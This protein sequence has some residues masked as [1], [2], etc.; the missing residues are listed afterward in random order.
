MIASSVT[1]PLSL[2]A[3]KETMISWPALYSPMMRSSAASKTFTPSLRVPTFP[4]AHHQEVVGIGWQPAEHFVFNRSVQIEEPLRQPLWEGVDKATQ[5]A[6]LYVLEVTDIEEISKLNFAVETLRY[7][8]SL[9]N[10]ALARSVSPPEHHNQE[11]AA[12]HQSSR[13]LSHCLPRLRV[14]EGA[15]ERNRNI[16]RVALGLDRF[17]LTNLKPVQRVFG[18]RSRDHPR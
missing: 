17:H 10:V 5:A 18:S 3:E 16:D 2:P 7:S 14:A 13:Q 4:S 9:Q 12:R 8:A 1:T 15:E 11:P 6:N